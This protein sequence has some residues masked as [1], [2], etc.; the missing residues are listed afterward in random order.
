MKLSEI[1]DMRKHGKRFAHCRC[2][3]I[4]EDRTS[5]LKLNAHLLIAG[6]IPLILCPDCDTAV[7]MS[8]FKEHVNGNCDLSAHAQAIRDVG[9][10]QVRTVEARKS[11]RDHK[12]AN[13][14]MN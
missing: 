13:F 7:M 14:I 12:A 3:S 2:F 11:K 10:A 4:E 1:Y 5:W 8:S 6:H 9:I